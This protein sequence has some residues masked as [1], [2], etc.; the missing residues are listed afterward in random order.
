M[1]D[2]PILAPRGTSPAAASRPETPLDRG[3]HTYE[4]NPAPWWMALIWVAF[5]LFAVVYLIR[6]LIE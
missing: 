5:L 6:N 1:A 2:D 4:A 3:Y